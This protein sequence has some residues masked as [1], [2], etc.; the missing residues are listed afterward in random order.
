MIVKFKNRAQMDDASDAERQPQQERNTVTRSVISDQHAGGDRE[1]Q[2][3]RNNFG[4]RPGQRV[5]YDIK[6]PQQVSKNNS[7]A[8]GHDCQPQG[9]S[10]RAYRPNLFGSGHI[11]LDAPYT[12]F[13]TCGCGN[14]HGLWFRIST[15]G[16]YLSSWAA[17]RLLRGNCS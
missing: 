6:L 16:S 14:S 11:L 3:G 15:G 9:P 12:H 8:A 4:A 5:Q 1:T 17:L 7:S 13:E 2:Q 10:N